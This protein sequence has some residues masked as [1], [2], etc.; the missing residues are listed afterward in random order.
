MSDFELI[1]VGGGLASA[2]ALRSYREAGGEGRA[3]LVSEDAAVPYHRP[4]LSKRFLRGEIEREGTLVEPESFY[5]EHD[6]ELALET[7]ARG[8]DPGACRLEL[9]GGRQVSYRRLLL[10][11]GASP[12]RLD[13]PGGDL[14]GVFYL[15][16]LA[17]SER[18]RAATTHGERAVVVGAGFIGMEVAASLRRLGL[19]VSLV[20]QGQSLFAAFG[21]PAIS[22][23]LA[24]LYRR[25]GV[26]LV[27]GDG[28][29]EFRG[30]EGRLQSVRTTEGRELVADLAVIGIGVVPST[31]FLEGSGLDVEDGI[32]VNDRFETGAPSIYAVGDVARF[33]D[34]VLGKQRRI[35][36]WSNAN[37]QGTEVGKALAGAQI[38]YDNVSSFF[39]EVFGLSLKS[40]GDSTEFD[41]QVSRGSLPDAFVDF[42]L[43]G[44][45]L[46]GTALTGLDEDAE[47]ELKALIRRRAEVSDREKL[48]DPSIPLAEAFS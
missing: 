47:N 13:A 8:I 48:A 9:S 5:A 19:E 10:A 20:H 4:P 30:E 22:A 41:G 40:F 18:I 34:P 27:L 21:S 42:L 25:E 24:E 12:R 7:S 33:D 36:H 16:T 17:D 32:V 3:L 29:A 45:R 6:V 14:G 1:V 2:R 46:V 26:E 38:Y 43:L 23:Y 39:S 35:E 37:Y 11:T 31:G 15:R 28:V 44:D